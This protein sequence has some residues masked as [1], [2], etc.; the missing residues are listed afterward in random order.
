MIRLLA[1]F[2][3]GVLL[4]LAAGCWTND[5]GNWDDGA[6]NRI[7]QPGESVEVK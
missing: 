2:A 4:G 5:S 7:M 1:G 6:N 3:V